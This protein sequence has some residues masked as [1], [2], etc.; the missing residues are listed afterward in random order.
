MV[1]IMN[2]KSAYF[3]Q[4]LSILRSY[5]THFGPRLLIVKTS[6]GEAA[7]YSDEVEEVS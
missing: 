7:F 1:K 2:R 3:G 5:E 6:V 4:V